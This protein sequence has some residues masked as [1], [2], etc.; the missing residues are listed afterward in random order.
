MEVLPFDKARFKHI[1]GN[2]VA[3]D[4]NFMPR[5]NLGMRKWE[6]KTRYPDGT[7]KIVVLYDSGFRITGEVVEINE[8]KTREERNAEIR[9]LYHE[10]GLSQVFLGILFHIS[11]PSVSIIVNGK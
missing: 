3:E 11:Q 9:R 4:F 5:S 10:K 1:A 8:F 2:G 6:I 7:C